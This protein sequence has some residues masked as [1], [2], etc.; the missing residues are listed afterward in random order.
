MLRFEEGEIPEAEAELTR[1]IESATPGHDPKLRQLLYH[2]YQDRATVR[3]RANQWDDALLDLAVAE[4]FIDDLSP[5][6]HATGRGA[7]ADARARILS[8]PANPLEDLAEAMRQ[9]RKIREAGNL[10]FAADDIESRLAYRAGDW[11]RAAALSRRAAA[12]LGEQGWLGAAAICQRRA[13]EALLKAGDPEGAEA[14]L[15][16]ARRQIDEFGTPL[17]LAQTDLVHA[18]LLSARSDHD[19]AWEKAL[20]A[21]KQFDGL[22]RRFSVLSDQQVFLIDKLERYGDAFAIALGAGGDRGCLRAWSVA[23]RSKS[24]YL[25]QLVAS[26][27]V[28]LFEG[29]DP[30]LLRAFQEAGEELDRLETKYGLMGFARRESGAGHELAARLRECSGRKAGLLK[31]L[32]RSNSRWARVNVPGELDMSVQVR[33]LPD[34]WSVLSYYWEYSSASGAGTRE[35]VKLNIFWTDD[36]KRPRH[37]VTEWNLEC[38]HLL[39]TSRARLRGSVPMGA[40]LIPEVLSDFILPAKVWGSIAENTRLLI[41]PHGL[42]QLLPLH[43]MTLSSGDYAAGRWAVQYLPSLSLL[44]LGSQADQKDPV[45]LIGCM[46]DGFGDGPLTEVRGELESLS[47]LWSATPSRPVV[48]H[49]LAPE[50]S[51]EAVGAGIET[52]GTFGV[53]HAACHGDFPHGRPFD[54]G[55]RLGSASVRASDFFGIRLDGAVASF[56]ACSLGRHAESLGERPVV[57]DEWIGLFL[58][59]LYAGIRC[60]V[61]SLWDAYSEPA[62]RFMGFLHVALKRGDDPAAAMRWAQDRTASETPYPATWANWYAVGLPM[63]VRE[64]HPPGS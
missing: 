27:D 53:L 21:L 47:A 7:V 4:R 23:E 59:L 36:A 42:L 46:Q 54:A 44:P 28:S 10:D 14:E 64:Q 26:A 61:A 13:A 57:G 32:M 37:M 6:L 30:A 33:Q 63:A 8:E 52:W 40:N 16:V 51:P 31:D 3:R 20:K 60:V 39:E 34:G 17:D 45:L 25:C 62:A 48:H 15:L 19:E 12:T 50:G 18:K 55:L 1:L 22:I 38:L 9:V 56:S 29:V 41:S 2:L 35:G 5:L 58:P 11:P 49:L 24:F 43:A